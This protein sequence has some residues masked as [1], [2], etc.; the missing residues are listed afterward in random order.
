MVNEPL[1][2][3]CRASCLRLAPMP[4]R[5]THRGER[6]RFIEPRFSSSSFN[7]SSSF[8]PRL[9]INHSILLLFVP[10]YLLLLSLSSKLPLPLSL[11]CSRC[12]FSSFHPHLAFLAIVVV[13]RRA[14]FFVSALYPLKTNQPFHC[15]LWKSLIRRSSRSLDA[16]FPFIRLITSR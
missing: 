14:L 12:T 3:G 2:I 15:T 4:N 16:V 7:L 10:L 5:L 1:T 13:V 11:S 9:F 6:G 8:S